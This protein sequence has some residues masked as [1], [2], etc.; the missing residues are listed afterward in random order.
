LVTLITIALSSGAKVI[1]YD[2]LMDQLL[3]LNKEAGKTNEEVSV[4]T[5]QIASTLKEI[6]QSGKSQNEEFQKSC[7]AGS[8][9]IK[10]NVEKI[11][12]NILTIKS[13]ASKAEDENKKIA[14]ELSVNQKS[15]KDAREELKDIE[16]K[17]SEKI[18]EIRI[19]G[20]EAEQKLA[21][22]K[23]LSDIITDELL[24]PEGSSFIQLST[25]KP[26]LQELKS[27][28]EKSH[29]TLY[30]PLVSTLIALTETRGFSDQKIL[31]QI[32]DLLGKLRNNLLG[33]RKNQDKEGR[34][35]VKTLKTQA[36][37]KIKQ[38]QEYGRLIASG[39]SNIKGNNEH[40][41]SA[42]KE[43]KVL[44]QFVKRKEKEGDDWEKFCSKRDNVYQN[45]K[46]TTELLLKKVDDVN[47]KL[48]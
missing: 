13:N 6:Q 44:E 39:Q 25:I 14:D 31:R 24:K 8:S 18:E 15:I 38:I 11:N 5:S 7:K 42:A 41:D 43:V 19:Y 16:K 35:Q 45:E 17:I 22:I 33:F 4:L 10:G 47:S 46:E 3:Q 30:T 26:K 29:Q 28:L 32:L 36:K 9:L 2:G 23:T 27:L 40:V 37:E 20:V 1:S 12:A 21:V 48:N 34:E